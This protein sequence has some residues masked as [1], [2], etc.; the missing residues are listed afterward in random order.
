MYKCKDCTKW[1][2]ST[3]GTVL[4][5]I[6]KKDKW[7]MYLSCMQRN[8]PIKK[9]AIEV[10]ICIQTSFNWRHKILSILS[11]EVPVKLTGRVEC[12]ELEMPL[13]NKGERNLTRKP[14]RRSSDFKRNIATKEITTVQVVSAIDENISGRSSKP[15]AP[16]ARW[17]RT[18][19]SIWP[20][21]AGSWR[22][23]DG[24]PARLDPRPR[25]RSR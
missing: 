1:F 16:P 24:L 6:K 17:T 2:S 14:R 21:S 4:W 13:S 18:W 19:R 23:S 20:T 22:G 5:D 8:I 12:D 11:V 15:T 3:T 7:Q 25:E 9:A 10:G